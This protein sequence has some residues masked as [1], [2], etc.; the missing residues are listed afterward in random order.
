MSGLFGTTGISPRSRAALAC[1]PQGFPFQP[2]GTIRSV[3]SP[4][5]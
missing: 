5:P 3:V 2:R 1:G 4:A